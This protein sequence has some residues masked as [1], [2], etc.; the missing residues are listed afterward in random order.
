MLSITVMVMAAMAG[1][2]KRPWMDRAQPIDQ[3][4]A[5]LLGQMTIEEKVNQ[6]LHVWVT[7][8]DDNIMSTYG[9]T[10]IGAAYLQQI[11]ANSSCNTDP[12]CRL[13]ARNKLQAYLVNTSRLGIPI[14]MVCETL[15]SDFTTL[16]STATDVTNAMGTA[17]PMPVAQGSSWNTTL[18]QTVASAIAAESRASGA[19][20]GFS[21]EL[22]VIT[23]PRFGRMVENFGSDPYLV[24]QY[25]TAA[26][27]G[28]TGTPEE[29]NTGPDSYI[30][31]NKV[32]SEGKHFAAYGYGGHDGA[33]ADVSIP[34]LY[35]IYLRPW[36]AF[37]KAGGRGCMA[38][39]NSVNGQPCHSSSWLL[40][41]IFRNELG[42]A[43]CLIGSDFDDIV[44]LNSFWTA[45]PDKYPGLSA[46]TDASIQALG[47]G[48]DVDLGGYSYPSLLQAAEKGLVN[49]TAI[50]RAVSNVLRT[51]FASGIFD[52]P[53]TPTSTLP[54]IHGPE[55]VALAKEAATQ[56][57][58]LLQ[59]PRNTLPLKPS[60]ARPLNIALLGTNAG[61]NDPLGTL[62][63]TS[64]NM[65]GGYTFPIVAGQVLTMRDAFKTVQG[66]NVTYVRGAEITGTDTSGIP[67]AVALVNNNITDVVVIG[68][69]DSGGTVGEATDRLELDVA[70]VQLDLLKAVL[71][72]GKEVVLVLINGRVQTFGES[73]NSRYGPRN[74]LLA[75]PNLSVLEAWLPGEQGGPAIVDVLLGNV[76][77]TGRLAQPF[78]ACVGQIHA[79][80]VPWFHQR[81]GDYG[82]GRGSP[83]TTKPREPAVSGSWDPIWCFGYGL[84]YSNYTMSG[85]RVS[86]TT[87]TPTSNFTATVVVTE[88]P[89]VVT[90]QGAFT[91]QIYSMQM[92][93][94]KQVRDELN[95]I[96]F[97]K[98]FIPADGS[99]HPITVSMNVEDMGYTTWNPATGGHVTGT[100][101]GQYMIFACYSAC[102]CPMNVTIN[103]V[104]AAHGR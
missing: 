83:F 86:S 50:D 19:N 94:S 39:H 55:H 26:V 18:V 28:L 21:P 16:A 14:T 76:Q 58:V 2:G 87:L 35:D 10:G 23:D 65:V 15:H 103:V 54:V 37:V 48:L 30:Q 80:T 59:N 100:E 27:Y 52:E 7:D 44:N 91:L 62:C 8:H 49:M 72:T 84:G 36:K 41:D 38:A 67:E 102:N 46:A 95:L 17:F 82:I 85:F 51:K 74:A 9:T 43:N 57:I 88:K 97:Q 68:L 99:A 11:S 3:R 33:P 47:A 90:P 104:S 45:D 66:V 20:F 22:Q 98:E 101:V 63:D 81:Q 53:I 92:S 93:A 1:H 60:V 32:I 42:C 89:P 31:Q 78:P 61:C 40:T 75:Y 24:S 12:V 79:W 56:G 77:P 70:G 69:G 29:G 71:D 73:S 34:A 6:M 96:G 5:A 13:E 25:A 4:V 64:W